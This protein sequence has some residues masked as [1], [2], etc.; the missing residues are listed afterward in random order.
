MNYSL[1]QD[2]IEWDVPNWAE[3]LAFWQPVIDKLPKD[4]KILAIGE[5]GGGLSLWLAL[6]GFHVVCSDR[7]L[8][9]Q[10]AMMLHQKYKVSDKITYRELDIFHIDEAEVYDLVLMKSVIGGLKLHYHDAASRNAA[11]QQQAIQ[12]IHALL[13]PGGYLL[14]ADNLEGAFPIRYL[15][16][17]LHKNKAW[18][19]FT[20]AQLQSLFTCFQE[21]SVR[22]FGVFP[23]K[24]AVTAFNSLFF[25]FNKYLLNRLPASSKYIAFTIARK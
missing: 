2:I 17:R 9:L 11:A 19:Y 20:S 13:K 4:S 12:K 23:T 14:T 15:R 1:K 16:T 21:V 7:K 25:A 22:Y 8:P 24:F 6:Q 3:A 18:H 5:R 10:Q